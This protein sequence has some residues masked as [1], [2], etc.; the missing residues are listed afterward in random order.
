MP[1]P[2]GR[3][4][5][6]P[7]GAPSAG[8]V[9]P[10]GPDGES[11]ARRV[12]VTGATG[13]LGRHL[14]VALA[15]RGFRLRILARRDPSHPLWRDLAAEVVPGDLDDGAALARLVC[16]ADIVIHAAGLIRALSRHEFLAVN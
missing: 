14:L 4:D 16:D 1:D 2:S 8:A 12:A 3:P 15:A 7:V 13:F 11:P 6:S 5:G 10:G 9:L